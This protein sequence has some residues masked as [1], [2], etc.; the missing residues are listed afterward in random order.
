MSY[1]EL[2]AELQM[3]FNQEVERI[4]AFIRSALAKK[5]HR[6]GLIVGMSGGIDSSVSAALAVKALG[7]KKVFAVLMPET[8]SSSKSVELATELAEF[9][10]ISYRVENIASALQGLG[11]Y[12]RRDDAIREVLPSYTSDWKSKIVISNSKDGGINHFSVFAKD[13]AGK[14]Y[15]EVLPLS[16][17]LKIVAATNFKQRVR[18]TMEYYHADERNFAVIGT[19]NLLEYDQ[20][21]FVKNGDGSA[22]I[23]PICH[24]YKT[25][26]YA[27][28][29]HLGLPESICNTTPTTDTYSLE[30]GQDE[31]YFSLSYW[32]MDIALLYKKQDRSPAELASKLGIDVLAAEN[33]YN[34]IEQK[35]KTTKYLHMPPLTLHE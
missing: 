2:D 34:D 27:L 7:P 10:G 15:Q 5:L 32:E 18:K 24:L 20:G 26:V 21:F 33:V 28:A 8:D 35:R 25:Q 3:D 19:P 9:L 29:R 4:C 13:P 11:C 6:R 14:E 12:Q 17:Y 31:F 16:A 30:Q 23:K 22:D 1:R